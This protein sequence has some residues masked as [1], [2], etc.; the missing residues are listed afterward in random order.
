MCNFI[1]VSYFTQCKKNINKIIGHFY[2]KIQFKPT[3]GCRFFLTFSQKIIRVERDMFISDPYLVK[4]IF[5]VLLVRG[6]TALQLS[7]TMSERTN[8]QF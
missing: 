5:T 7:Y 8:I 4:F 1:F 3:E 6:N 2:L